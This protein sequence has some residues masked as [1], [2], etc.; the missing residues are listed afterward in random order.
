MAQTKF[1]PD[2]GQD[3]QGRFNFVKVKSLNSATIGALAHKLVVDP[4]EAYDIDLTCQEEGFLEP[5]IMG[6]AA[7][8]WQFMVI[9]VSIGVDSDRILFQGTIPKNPPTAG[10]SSP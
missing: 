2:M 9:A 7:S 10:L 1:D 8:S 6:A 5:T 4:A 3:F